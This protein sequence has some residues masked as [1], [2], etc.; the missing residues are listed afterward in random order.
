MGIPKLLAGGTGTPN[1]LDAPGWV[2]LMP[3]AHNGYYDT[4]L[5]L[6]YVGLALLVIFLVTSLHVIGRVADHDYSRA[7]L[8]LSVALFIIIYNSLETLWLRAFDMS[9]VVFVIVVAEATRYWQPLPLKAPVPIDARKIGRSWPLARHVEAPA[10]GA[11]VRG[12]EA[13]AGR[14]FQI[15]HQTASGGSP[16]D[17]MRR[18][19][20]CI[21]PEPQVYCVAPGARADGVPAS[22]LA[23]AGS[24]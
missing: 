3:N 1:I 4:M 8:L 2:K 23:L 6:G 7:W 13:G 20:I 9:W 5:E 24:A 21:H 17:T 19:H 12:C 14:L 18:G 11:V 22:N 16:A 15:G 10:G